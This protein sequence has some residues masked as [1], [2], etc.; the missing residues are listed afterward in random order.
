VAVTSAAPDLTPK[1]R[2]G[3]PSYA[4]ADGKPVV[5]VQDAG[6]FKAR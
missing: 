4:D 5:F 1:I 3:M 6:K 2:H